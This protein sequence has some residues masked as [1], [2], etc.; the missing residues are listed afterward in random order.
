M[1]TRVDMGHRRRRSEKAGS[2]A[3]SQA[4]GEQTIRPHEGPEAAGTGGT[5]ASGS[6][7]RA[8][9]GARLQVCEKPPALCGPSCASAG[10]TLRAQEVASG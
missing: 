4:A 5:A 1:M 9:H 7:A 3:S 6:G 8:T 10:R 2:S